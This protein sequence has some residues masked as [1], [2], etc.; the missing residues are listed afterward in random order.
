MG[1]VRDLT[2][3]FFLPFY[4]VLICPL[5]FCATRASQAPAARFFLGNVQKCKTNRAFPLT[6][7]ARRDTI[8]T[9]NG[10]RRSSAVLSSLPLFADAFSIFLH[11][12][13]DFFYAALH[14]ERGHRVHRGK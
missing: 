6:R 9:D 4:P 10:V 7:R 12:Q 1:H 11:G 14:H 13:E 3:S 5:R 2:G 8:R